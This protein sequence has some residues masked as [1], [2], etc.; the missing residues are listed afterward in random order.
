MSVSLVSWCEH[1]SRGTE[2]RTKMTLPRATWTLALSLLLASTASAQHQIGCSG[3]A[4]GGYAPLTEPDA[5]VSWPVRRA[6]P[7]SPVGRK[8][9]IESASAGNTTVAGQTPCE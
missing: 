7:P 8:S 1:V 9:W 6:R 4:A 3:E 2:G 5:T